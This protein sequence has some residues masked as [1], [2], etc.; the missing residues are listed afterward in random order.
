MNASEHAKDPPADERI[1]ALL[2][3]GPELPSEL[4]FLKVSAT[5]LTVRACGSRAEALAILRSGSADVLIAEERLPDGDAAQLFEEIQKL[6]R[7]GKP[8]AFLVISRASLQLQAEL[9]R[10]RFSQVDGVFFR[11]FDEHAFLSA[12]FSAVRRRSGSSRVSGARMSV[13]HLDVELQLAGTR[14]PCKGTVGNL[15]RGGMFLVMGPGQPLPREGT[16]FTF[17]IEAERG[18]KV[19]IEGKGVIRWVRPQA[20]GG[21]P[22]GIGTQFTSI[23]ERGL[24]DLF[25]LIKNLKRGTGGKP[26]G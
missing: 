20:V 23:S 4:S 21:L 25:D 14:Q 22:S 17:T 13:D 8:P 19:R 6:E 9:L 15:G 12:L 26:P 24:Q 11:P 16:P 7:L 5:A 1:Q 18:R 10:T 3:G 2:V